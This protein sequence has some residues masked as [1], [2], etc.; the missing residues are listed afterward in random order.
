[1]TMT[2]IKLCGLTGARD[3]QAA[4]ELMPEYVGFVFADKSRRKVTP[5]Q[6]FRLKSELN[7]EIRAVGV[8]VDEDPAVVA[9]M[10]NLGIIDIAQLHGSEDEDY[11]RSLRK[12]SGKPVIKAFTVRTRRDAEIAENCSADYV[13]LDAGKGSGKVFDWSVINDFGRPYFLAGGLNSETA[14]LALE[15]L[16]PYALDVSSG[17]ETNG[18]KDPDKMADFVFAV[19]NRSK[20]DV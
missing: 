6:A 10:L 11:I 18:V 13:L 15:R 8:F 12:L 20:G 16:R 19:R 9:S 3:I 2:K 17:I 4:N 5:A 7:P 14:L 1:M